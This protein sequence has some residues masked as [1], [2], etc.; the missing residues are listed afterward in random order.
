[1]VHEKQYPLTGKRFIDSKQRG[2]ARCEV[3]WNWHPAPLADYD[4]WYVVSGQGTMR[5]GERSYPA[6]KGACFVVHP[7]D[8][9]HA[10]QNLEDRL[11]VIFIHFRMADALG[12]GGSEPSVELLHERVVYVE[13]THEFEML[14]H[15]TLECS[16]QQ[17]LWAEEEFDCLLKQILI[18]LF[19]SQQR[20]DSHAA[21][22]KKQAQA[23]RRVVHRIHEGAGHRFPLEELAELVGL[24]P[25]YLSKLFKAY[26]G[27]SLKHYMTQVRMERAMHLLTETSMNVSQVSDALRYSTVFLFSKQFKQHYGAPPSAYAL[28]SLPSR[29]HH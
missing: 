17:P 2:K 22:S 14:L 4:L 26:T 29:P 24:N 3:G 8:Q 18:A 20:S 15:R 13:D 27:V 28:S 1:M 19:R 7:G 10:E 21:V 11:T 9:P 6:R 5:I 12:L 25:A 23:I 16:Y